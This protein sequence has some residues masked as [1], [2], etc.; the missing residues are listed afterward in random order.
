MLTNLGPLPLDRIHGMLGMFLPGDT[1][2]AEE[3]RDFLAQM[4]REDRLD[5]AG[6]LYKL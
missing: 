6:G 1:T 2:T 4:V 3:L 5:V